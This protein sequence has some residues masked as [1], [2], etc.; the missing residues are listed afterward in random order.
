MQF[1]KWGAAGVA[2]LVA[3]LAALIEPLALVFR[4]GHARH[5]VR[6]HVAAADS[7]FNQSIHKRTHG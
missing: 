6:A 1:Q 4:G 5:Q 7:A 3:I 2:Q